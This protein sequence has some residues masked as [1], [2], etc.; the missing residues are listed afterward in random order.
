MFL[1]ILLRQIQVTLAV[2]LGKENRLFI[3]A[4]LNYVVREILR[5]KSGNSRH[6]SYIANEG[7]GVKEIIVKKRMCPYYSNTQI[8]PNN[9]K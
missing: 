4:P 1:G 2:S 7:Q 6:G 5:N 8:T 3:I 9:T